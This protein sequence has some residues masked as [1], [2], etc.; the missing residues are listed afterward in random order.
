MALYIDS[1]YL[2]DIIATA[3]TLPLAGVTTNPTLLLA[4]RERGQTLTPQALVEQLLSIVDGDILMQP[5]LAN[6]E[7]ALREALSL[8][9]RAPERVVSKIPL[10]Q[11][12]L[13]VARQLKQRRLRVAFTAVTTVA[14]AYIAAQSGAEIVIPYY[15]RLQRCGVNAAE[16]I[17]MM[18]QV[19]A[20]QQ[21]PT[22]II[23]ASIKNPA[24]A[25][26]ALLAGASDLT[27]PPAVLLEMATDPETEQAVAR[28]EQDWHKMKTL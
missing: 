2:D 1:A 8:V 19:L 6:E 20:R 27:I 4:A 23:V 7:E 26:S 22:R 11:A 9:E 5:S 12:G 13:R 28:F 15:N 16:R 10:T 14:Q 24:E 21:L 3:R 18:A 17:G 25:A